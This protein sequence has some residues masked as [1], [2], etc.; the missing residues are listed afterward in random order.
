[1]PTSFHH[2]W[3]KTTW[4]MWQ[5]CAAMMSLVGYL[6]KDLD[7]FNLFAENSQILLI[8]SVIPN[9]LT[10]IYLVALVSKQPTQLI[11]QLNSSL[12]HII[13]HTWLI[14]PSH[15][16]CQL[17]ILMNS[18][19]EFVKCLRF[20]FYFKLNKFCLKVAHYQKIIHFYSNLQKK[21]S[22]QGSDFLKKGY[23]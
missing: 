10:F 17:E 7:F 5:L 20:F 16:K 4:P 13:C 9:L 6:L 11:V 1:M 12:R 8:I 22:N 21:V 23:L 14:K 2:G 3:P 18:N 15:L 19:G